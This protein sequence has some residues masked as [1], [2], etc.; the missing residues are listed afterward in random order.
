MDDT[1]LI[2]FLRDT[3]LFPGTTSS[4]VSSEVEEVLP[5]IFVRFSSFSSFSEWACIIFFNRLICFCWLRYIS[6][7]NNLYIWWVHDFDLNK[8]I[9]YDWKKS[10][11]QQS[12]KVEI[13]LP[14]SKARGSLSWFWKGGTFGKN[15]QIIYVLVRLE[16][17][18]N[19][20]NTAMK[21]VKNK[22]IYFITELSILY[23]LVPRSLHIQL[24]QPQPPPRMRNVTVAGAL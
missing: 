4:V 22:K 17:R 6:S 23:T 15:D 11:A 24:S 5:L 16:L 12:K 13:A 9:C 8:W 7:V 1:Y 18:L 20:N 2:L 10:F 3:V 14:L 19:T 21:E